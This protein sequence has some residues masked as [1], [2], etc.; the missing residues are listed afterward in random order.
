MRMRSVVAGVVGAVFAAVLGLAPL[1]EA[2]A[3]PV[4]QGVREVQVAAEAFARGA[5]L[6]DWIDAVPLPAEASSTLPMVVRLADTQFLV[7]QRP[8]TFV[9]RA[10][11]VNDAAALRAIGQYPIAFAPQY[12]RV[13]LHRLRVLRDGRDDDRLAGTPVRFLQ[14]ETALEVGVYSGIVSAVLLVEDLRVGDTLHVAYSVEG[15]NP[16]FGER[17]ADDASWDQIEPVQL[18]RVK[19]VHPLD[20]PIQWRLVGDFKRSIAPP[21][22]SEADG[23]RTLRFEERD[24]A[25]IDA[26]P[27]IPPGYTAWRYLQ[28]SEWRGWN[29]VAR[30]AQGLF[31]PSAA[32][33]GALAPVV[34]RLRALPTPEQRVAA[35]LQWVQDEIRYHS[36]ALGESSHRP[37]PPEQTVQRRYG[38]CKDKSFLLIELLRAL[39]VEAR[40]VLV[41][42]QRRDGLDALLPSP[43]AFD[44]VLVEARV[45]GVAYHLDPTRLGQRGRLDRMGQALLGF[46]ALPVAGDTNA[47]TV[48]G[49]PD[50][51]AL[52]RNE[53]SERFVLPSFSA[54]GRLEVRQT[55][56]GVVAEA[57]R[58]ELARFDDERM[59]RVA[60]GPYERRYPGIA[61]ASTPELR[62]EQEVNRMTFVASYR[63]PKLAIEAGGEYGVRFFPSNL[64]GVLPIPPG[65][66]R[67]FPAILP[68]HP[69]VAVY[70]LEIEWPEAVSVIADPALQR[71]TAPQFD[72]E[73]SHSFRGNRA[74]LK[75]RMTTTA[76]QVLPRELPALLE[77]TRKLEQALLRGVV[78]VRRGDIK[79]SGLLGLGTQTLQE[80]MQR[81]LQQQVERTGRAIADG[82]L[83]GDDLAEALCNRAEALSDLGRSSD[84]LADARE[85]VKTATALPRAFEC[86]GNLLF[87]TG[88][89]AGAVA[90]YSR[91]IALGDAD[92]RAYY[93]RGHARFYLGRLDEAADDFAQAVA[94]SSDAADSVYARL[95]Q[96]W[97]LR[98]LQRA[99]P[100]EL[101]DDAK[102]NADGDWPRPALAMLTGALTVE[103]ALAAAERKRGDERVMALAE[104]WF[105]VGQ[106]HLAGGDAAR[107]R[108]A[109]AKAREAGITMYV[110]HI[111]AGFELA[112]LDAAR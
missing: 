44:H 109:F 62:D 75:L 10:I 2:S 42:L 88:D 105:Y 20:R 97:T 93:R 102:A 6:P 1:C 90:D 29:D 12:Q 68:A 83:K 81:R 51:P 71:V 47:L 94:V 19:L 66:T 60:L 39:D 35:A 48:I 77:N 61:L 16:V 79:D 50:V 78:V 7:A 55:F 69:Y 25:A 99:L 23:R 9:Q 103:Q 64:N 54:D 49:A 34:E 98:R 14:R 56:H 40:P 41:S 53:L 72:A 33:A 106:H 15:Q 65:I 82:R 92:F 18:R 57:L 95:W 70:A 76:S 112:R 110:E 52:V 17:F 43:G 74:Q 104:A 24:L 27:A 101:V 22:I 89:F 5:P 108:A 91:S 67:N 21:R 37:H 107:A 111:A 11:R 31:T 87:A 45:G 100:A 4:E 13:A 3:Q 46:Q 38:D 84:G 58:I 63:V 30:W 32:A 36:I 26:E 8:V 86:R 85:A 96:A 59:R 80:S 73:V 28:F